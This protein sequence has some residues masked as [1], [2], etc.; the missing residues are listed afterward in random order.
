MRPRVA[1]IFTISM[2]KVIVDKSAAD[3]A[4]KGKGKGSQAQVTSS[5]NKNL[6]KSATR[7]ARCAERAALAKS[8]AP[9]RSSSMYI[10]FTP[11]LIVCN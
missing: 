9:K 7:I 4:G 1:T 5:N 6:V 3:G 11:I 2:P 10:N 8:S